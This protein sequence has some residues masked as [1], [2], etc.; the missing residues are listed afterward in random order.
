MGNRQIGNKQFC[1]SAYFDQT[2][3]GEEKEIRA[4][5]CKGDSGGPVVRVVEFDH[6]NIRSKE[7]AV[8]EGVTSYGYPCKGTELLPSVYTHV[9]KYMHWIRKYTNVM[10][11]VNGRIK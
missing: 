1:A 7:R 11:T 9:S 5:A 8:L 3:T 6:P 2:F 4:D 10:Y